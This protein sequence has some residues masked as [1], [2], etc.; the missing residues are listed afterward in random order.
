MKK[1]AAIKSFLQFIYA[2]GQTIAGTVDYAKLPADL[3]TKA[4]AQIDQIG[5]PA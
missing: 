2:D 3:I 1:G 4:K 5:V